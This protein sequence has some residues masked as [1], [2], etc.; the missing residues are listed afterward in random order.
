MESKATKF[1]K[2]ALS[3][4]GDGVIITDTEGKIIFI[5][6]IAEKLTGWNFDETLGKDF[7]SV[8]YLVNAETN[9]S[10]NS[11]VKVSLETKKSVGLQ[12]QSVL[13]AKDG[14]K[15]YVSASCSPIIEKDEIEGIIIVFRD[16]TT[17]KNLEIDRLNQQND[18]Q[19]IFE[20]APVGMIILNEDKEISKINGAAIDLLGKKRKILLEGNL[21]TV[22]AA[23]AYM[24]A[25]MD[26]HLDIV[27]KLVK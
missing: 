21:E 4:V 16:I 25:K 2:S 23:K 1:I 20:S 3:C 24:R 13:V 14:S 18:L 6:S 10:L 17:L 27:V 7:D 26:V 15:K 8:F 22:L 9:Q 11:P 19:L 12:D 5:N